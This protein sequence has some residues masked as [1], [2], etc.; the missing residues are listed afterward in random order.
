MTSPRDAIERAEGKAALLPG[1]TERFSGWGVMGL[2]FAS[3]DVIATRRFPANSLG[4]GYSAVWYRDPAGQWTIYADV[5]P[6]QGCARYFGLALA[7]A[8]TCPI[9]YEWSGPTELQVRVPD[10][11][12]SCTISVKSTVATRAMNLMSAVMPERAWRSP[13][14]LRLMSKAAG[15]MLRVGRLAM[16][17]RV[18]NGQDYIA[19]PRRIWMVESATLRVGDRIAGQVGPVAPQAKMG[20]FRIPQ[21]GILAIGNTAFDAFDPVRHSDAMS[22]GPVKESAEV[23]HA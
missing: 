15:P 1:T 2:P 21:R 20:D 3:G 7:E 4:P 16:A 17:G 11:D 12:I 18:P 9:E 13:R 6:S 14:V 5:P 23:R 10:A 8:V 19:N 22:M